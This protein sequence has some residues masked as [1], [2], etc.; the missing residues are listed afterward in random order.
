MVEQGE[1]NGTILIDR[2]NAVRS[3]DIVLI[4]VAQV[5]QVTCEIQSFRLMCVRI[6]NECFIVSCI[7]CL[8]K[9]LREG[10]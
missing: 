3:R 4:G 6:Q 2:R 5:K 9:V 8:D 1:S 10:H 7:V